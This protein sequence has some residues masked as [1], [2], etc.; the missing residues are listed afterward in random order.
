MKV[1]N[2][3][4]T[5]YI[6]KLYNDNKKS[7]NKAGVEDTTTKDRIELSDESK[8]IKKYFDQVKGSSTDS[9]NIESIKSAIQAGTYQVSSKELAEEILKKMKKY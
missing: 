7:T 9:K 3:G 5:H 2:T 6:E 8:E 1:N 4:Y